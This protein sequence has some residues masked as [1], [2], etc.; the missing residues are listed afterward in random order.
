MKPRKPSANGLEIVDDVLQQINAIDPLTNQPITADTFFMDW[1]VTNFVLD[2]SIADGR[3]HYANYSG[4][5]QA[6]QTETI[7]ACPQ[8]A[9]SRTVH[10]YAAD[11][12]AI[13]CSGDF[14]LS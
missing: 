11:Y 2:K 12:I 4:A 14:T 6:R 3:Y 5:H 13:E 1:V 8:Q 7:Y 10:Q 9:L